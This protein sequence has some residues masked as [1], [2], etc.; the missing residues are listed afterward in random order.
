MER[1]AED[2]HDYENLKDVP[3]IVPLILVIY[4]VK[5]DIGVPTKV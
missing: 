4:P 5:V 1:R 3:C 2:P